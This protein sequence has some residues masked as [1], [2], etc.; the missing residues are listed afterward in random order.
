MLGIGTV[1]V[2]QAGR[3]EKRF[4]IDGSLY[5]MQQQEPHII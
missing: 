2:T 5:Y 1:Y 4:F 3:T